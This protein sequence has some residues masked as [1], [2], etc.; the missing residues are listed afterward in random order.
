MF[1]NC[2]L[3]PEANP[4]IVRSSLQIEEGSYWTQGTFL[5]TVHNVGGLRSPL[6]IKPK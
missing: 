5:A 3:G 1:E 6:H 4:S 2:T